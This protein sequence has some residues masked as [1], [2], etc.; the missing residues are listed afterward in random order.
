MSVGYSCRNVAPSAGRCTNRDA[1][2]DGFYIRCVGPA[3]IEGLGA[4]LGRWW[5]DEGSIRSRRTTSTS[6]SRFSCNCL[7]IR[8]ARG[9]ASTFS[10][11]AGRISQQ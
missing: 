5:M 11:D 6:F 9:E 10:G 4:A 3:L 7:E 1:T 8:P 2:P